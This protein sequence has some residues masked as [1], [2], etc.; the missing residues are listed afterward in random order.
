MSL[1]PVL[2]LYAALFFLVGQSWQG[3]GVGYRFL[4][5]PTTLTSTTSASP[6]ASAELRKP[7]LPLHTRS[8]GAPAIPATPKLLTPPAVGT[9]IAVFNG[10][11]QPGLGF[12]DNGPSQQSPPDT[13]GS[14]G[15][16][17]YVEIINSVVGVYKRTDLSQVSKASFTTWLQLNP[18]VPLCDPQM[19]WDSSSQ[20][21]LYVVLGCNFGV[22]T[23]FFGWSKSTDPSD[24]VNGW[25]R[26]SANTPNLLPDYPKL[27][28]NSNYML[29]GANGFSDSTG[30]FVT[31]LILWMKTPAAGVASC[32]APTVNRVGT[33]LAKLKNGD[34]V[35]LTATPVPVNTMTNA[36]NGYVVS[37]YDPSGPPPTT[38]TKLAVWH[39]D[40]SG[41]LHADADISVNSYTIPGPAPD[42]GGDNVHG[43][44][45]L[46][47]RL[48]QAVGDPITG[49]YTQHTVNGTGGRSKATWYEIK[50]TLGT[51]LV[52]EGDISSTTEYV[53]N[54]SISP[55]LDG[56]GATIFYNRSSAATNVTI[57]AQGRMIWTPLGQM[58]PGEVVLGTGTAGDKDFSCNFTGNGEP[59]RW[60]DY[61]GA[62]PDPVIPWVVWGSNQTLTTPAGAAPNWV[63]RNYA[64]VGPP[65]RRVQQ[66]TPLPSPS[67]RGAPGQS[68]PIPT[69]PA[70]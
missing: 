57:G 15:P 5:S 64:I 47:G 6:T 56:E 52:Q 16:N 46:D 11:N 23:L 50:P 25:C 68:T 39:L 20:R 28:H 58:D 14:I 69:P 53:Y 19:Q 21:W 17:H 2:V 41:V 67:P 43:I 10:L 1:K 4:H 33:S 3:A 31:A 36:A 18:S 49:I 7:R 65:T 30:N 48:T 24:L 37:A 60:G 62:S 66:S 34:G 29:V 63:T 59:C 27:G 12:A 9:Q 13:T 51:P 8:A 55:R 32:T 44:D 45:T 38:E 42:L 40:S 35:T 70:R 22:D 26:F 61:S 54:A